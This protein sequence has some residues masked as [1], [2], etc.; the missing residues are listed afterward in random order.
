MNFFLNFHRADGLDKY[1]R[2]YIKIHGQAPNIVI[3]ACDEDCMGKVLIDQQY[4]IQ[5]NE[6]FYKDRLITFEEAREILRKCSNFTVVGEKIVKE[7]IEIGL[8]HPEA[9]LKVNNIPVAMRIV[10]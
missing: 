8:I 7:L 4:N 5:V 2:C 3:G 9:T 6:A 10:L 1:M